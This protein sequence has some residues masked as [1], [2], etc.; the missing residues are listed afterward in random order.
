V[1]ALLA[2][3]SRAV[4]EVWLPTTVDPVV[5][6]E[7]EDLAARRRVPVRAA[8]R[9]GAAL[10][11]AAR[12]APLD[13]VDLSALWSAPRPAVLAVDGTPS[14]SEL[15]SALR[16]AAVDD[17]GTPVLTGVVLPRQPSSRVTAAAAAAAA[18]AVE[19]LPLALATDLGAALA[20]ARSTGLR[21][22]GVAGSGPMGDV[23]E[24]GGGVVVVVSPTGELERSV[25]ARCDAVV[26]LR[27]NDLAEQVASVVAALGALRAPSAS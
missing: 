26:G 9:P 12:A 10:P 13:P 21:V 4:G 22:V 18:G 6:A 15:G 19:R 27:G 14:P 11:V 20:G 25:R 3:G 5:R 1:R 8:R 7:L 17:E 2:G 24:L 16:A 23:E